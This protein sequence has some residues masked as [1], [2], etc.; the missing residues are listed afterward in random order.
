MFLFVTG[1]VTK[2]VIWSVVIRSTLSILSAV[3]AGYKF[4]SNLQPRISISNSNAVDGSH[5][6]ELALAAMEYCLLPIPNG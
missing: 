5:E 3:N 1:H 2:Y 4:L 6:A